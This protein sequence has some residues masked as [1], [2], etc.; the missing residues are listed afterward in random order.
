VFRKHKVQL[1][2]H[3]VTI[4]MFRDRLPHGLNKAIF[5][6]ITPQPNT[7]GAC[8]A[9]ARAHHQQ[10]LEWDTHWEKRAK[11]LKD[12]NK[13]SMRDRVQLSQFTGTMA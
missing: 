1:V 9:A 6:H 13:G 12:R 3:S 7:L 4:L 8:I 5:E 11:N 10:W 2:L